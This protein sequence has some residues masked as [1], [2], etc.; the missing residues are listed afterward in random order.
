MSARLAPKNKKN[1]VVDMSKEE[2]VS[3]RASGKTYEA[4]A[5]ELEVPES[6]LIE[7]SKECEHEIANLK[8][9][10]LDELQD[11]HYVAKVKRMA[12][13]GEQVERMKEELFNRDLSDIPTDKLY[14]IFLKYIQLLKKEEVEPTFQKEQ[15]TDDLMM[16]SFK[17][18]DR[19]KAN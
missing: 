9:I 18:V 6:D 14:D 12:V 4:I 8:A 13:M 1:G 10:K 16:Q 17:S 5:K 2:F 3:L 15:S 11:K 7:W 19:W